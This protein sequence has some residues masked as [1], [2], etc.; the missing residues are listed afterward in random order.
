MS[1]LIAQQAGLSVAKRKLFE[2][3]M[4]GD[5]AADAAIP[6][7]PQPDSAPPLSFAQER[8]WFLDQLEPE[9]SAYNICFTLQ[10]S[11]SL[12]VVALRRAL[13]EI[14][15]RH[16]VLRAAFKNIKGQPLQVIGDVEELALLLIDLSELNEPDVEVERIA[17]VEALRPFE[18]SEGRLVRG[19][20][21]KLAEEEHVL[22]FTMHHII[23]DGWSR[24]ILVK[25]AAALY[26]SYHEGR[27][28]TLPEL[29]LQ[30]GDYASWQREYLQGERLE[31]GLSYWRKQLAGA[32]EVLELPLDYPRPAVRN[33]RGASEHRQLNRELSQRLRELS[34]REG[35]TLYMLLLAAF[36]TLLWRYS[37]QEQI[38]VGT[39]AA[40]RPRVE[41][42]GL[43]GFFV[44]TLVLRTDFTGGPSF[45]ELLGRV[46]EVCVGAYNHQE[47]PFKKLVEELEPER[48]LN[49]TPLFQVMFVYHNLPR[50]Q[51]KLPG[52]TLRTLAAESQTAKFDL[53]LVINDGREELQAMFE[54]NRDLFQSTTITRLLDQFETLLGSIVVAPE[55]KVRRLSLMSAAEV[56]EQLKQPSEEFETEGSLASWFEAV[57][58]RRREATAVVCGGE[59]LSYGELNERANQLAHYLRKRGV[60]PEVRVGLSLER[61]AEMVIGLLGI[62]KAGGAYVPLEQ[63]YPQA[64]LEFMIADAGTQIIVTHETFGEIEAEST[65]NPVPSASA[66][67]ALYVIYTSGTTGKPKGTVVTQGNVQ[68]LFQ[69]SA[70]WY[71]F[72]E[73]DVWTL[74][75]SYGFDFSVWEMWGALLYGGKLVV[76][77]YL[78]SRTPAAFYE[79]LQREQVTVL[80]QTP[81]AF[82][83]LQQAVVQGQGSKEELPLR[84]VI[85]GGEALAVSRLREWYEWY[86]EAGPRLVNMYGITETTVHVS[87]RELGVRDVRNAGSPIGWALPDL[88][89]YVLDEELKPVPVG[90]P[91]ELYVGGRGLARGYLNQGG[92]T[93]ARFVPHPYSGRGGE[94]LYRS[95]DRGRRLASGE[96]EYLGRMDQQVKIRGHR[97]ELAEIE[98]VLRSHPTVREAVAMLDEHQPG[99]QRLV[100]YVVCKDEAV[101]LRRYAAGRLPHY[102]VPAGIFK[103]PHLPLTN[104]GKVDRRKLATIERA[105][106]PELTTLTSVRTPVEEV[107][108]ATMLEVLG[109]ERVGVDDSFFDLGGHSLLATQV[110]GRLQDA[111]QVELP[112]RLLFE[113]PTVSGLA[114]HIETAIRKEKG[115]C[116]PPIE[117]VLRDAPLPLSFAQ[118]RLWFLGQLEP[119]N[120]VYNIPIALRIKGELNVA[121]L[122]RSLDEIIARHESLRTKL[123]TRNGE[124]FQII[125]PVLTGILRLVDLSELPPSEREPL[126]LQLANDDARRPFDLAQGPLLRATLLRL[127]EQ[128]HIASLTMHHVTSDGWSTAVLIGEMSTLYDAFSNGQPSPLPPLSIQ[129]ADYAHWQRQWLQG[130]VLQSQLSYWK[131]KLAGSRPLLELPTDYS[132]PAIQT[133]RGARQSIALQRSLSN[134]LKSLCRRHQV[135]LFMTLL[136][137][138]KTLL[139]RYSN[140]EDICVGSPIANRVTR[141][142]EALIGYIANTLVLR[143]DLSGN[144][145]FAE[146]LA[147]VREVSLGAYAFQDLSF[148]KLVDELQ[149]ARDLS[150]S[151]LFQVMFTLQNM[152]PRELKSSGLRLSPIIVENHTAKFD[153]ELVVIETANGMTAT[154]EYNLDLFTGETVT[155]M[156]DNFAVM[157][158]SIVANPEQR[159][160]ELP[161]LS[162]HEQQFLVELNQ[163]KMPLPE[164]QYAHRLFELQVER[165]PDAVAAVFH[166]VELTYSELN[167]RANRW[168][169][170]LVEN[171]VGP[172]VLVGALCDRGVNLLTAMLAIAKAGGTYLPLD[173][174][175]P[176]DRLRLEI[177]QSSCGLVLADREYVSLIAGVK[178]I[179]FDELLHNNVANLPNRSTAND[180]AYVIYTSG[181]TGIPKGAMIENRGMVNHLFAKITELQMTGADRVAQTASQS[182]DI[183]VWQFIAPLL[184]GARVHV[185]HDEITHD[186]VRL[187]HE[188]EAQGITI[189]ETVPSL[190]RA[191]LD[192]NGFYPKL[193]GL[194]WL[195]ITGEALPPELCRQ[196]LS[197]YPQIP[198]LNAYGPT[199]CSDDVTHHEI[200]VPPMGNVVRMPIGHAVQNTRLY[201]LDSHGQPVPTGV[202]GELY[203]GGAGVGRGYLHDPER[204]AEVF[205]PDPFADEPGARL[206]RSGDL[207]RYSADGN[208]EFIGRRDQQMKI[209]GFRIELG[210]IEVAVNALPEVRESL[211]LA[212]E[213]SPGERYLVLYL[214]FDRSL[215]A[216]STSELRNLLK[217][218][219]PDYMIPR[220]FIVLDEFP[221]TS[222]GKIDRQALPVPDG[223]RPDLD[224]EFVAPSSDVEKE[225]ARIWAQVLGVDQV[226]TH[227]NFFELGGDS[228]LMIQIISRAHQAGISLTLRQVFQHQTIAELAQLPSL[229]QTIE[230]EQSLITGDMPLT[231][232]QHWFIEQEMVEPHHYN[233][234][235][236]LELRQPMR[237]ALLK[238]VVDRLLEH[239]DG[240]RLRLA[241]NHSGWRQ[242]ISSGRDERVFSVVD[243]SSLP[244]PVHRSAI[245]KAAERQQA[246]LSLSDGPVLR[247]TLFDRGSEQT[248]RLLIVVHHLT[249]DGVSWRILLEDL[250]SAYEQLARAEEIVLPPKTTSFKLW[251]ERLTAHAQN[252]EVR[253]EVRYWV[254]DSRRRRQAIPL[255]YP[256]GDNTVGSARLLTVFLNAGET[257]SLLQNIPTAYSTRIDEVLLTALVLTFARW[258]GR[259]RLLVDLE[260]HGREE[261][262]PDVDLSRTIGWFTA[263]YPVLLDI[264]GASGPRAALQAVKAQLRE[265][266]NR[267]L[268]YGL[269]RYLT[270]NSEIKEQ[271]RELPQA[272]V[273][274][275]YL[276][277]FDQSFSESSYFK[278]APEPNGTR[279]NRGQNR[280]HLLEVNGSIV[281]RELHLTWIYNEKLHRESTIRH[282]AHGFREALQVLIAGV[283][284]TEIYHVPGLPDLDL[285]RGKLDN[286]LAELK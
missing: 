36:Q 251:A 215:P 245:E 271:L 239:H 72:D 40:N 264:G 234:A 226:G 152:P 85:F 155:R 165:T 7:R 107:V 256:G 224:Q 69:A 75:H 126:A 44:N 41:L 273:I 216:L 201:V 1:N 20:L 240:F 18:L 180:L 218:R 171:G 179:S 142:V 3:W 125:A 81:S 93:A 54:Y 10:L 203:I 270:T 145:S 212:R 101:D 127:D 194:R 6:R 63:S 225:L 176:V 147:R 279:R 112:L 135:T 84:L 104:N 233:Q 66:E 242:F 76:V 219:L 82:W 55:T 164:E 129:Y 189:W 148:E 73:R 198:L 115:L 222:N 103:I 217:Q 235:V 89:L 211:A 247:F 132:R 70:R 51:L 92:L 5:H 231:P 163:T 59:Q 166:E 178:V 144:P 53:S 49:H 96:I 117:R 37:R 121:A 274:F 57:A 65:A 12:D 197:L 206:Y 175:H 154:M 38:S 146:L 58:A 188:I 214:V 153:L 134:A 182:F 90:V 236:L 199:E 13:S 255:D 120:P 151:P 42:E 249:I 136:A 254:T 122:D 160:A 167:E 227:D 100:A 280:R 191:A 86:G 161:L 213:E 282:L 34:Q 52:L 28:S 119:G 268:S 47:V 243:L 207:A 114:R 71:E 95:G 169:H 143:T 118:Q 200:S 250:Q 192:V 269:L 8:L 4:R 257:Q 177:T 109:I 138:F 19:M 131:E 265:L 278:L 170:W 130:D 74:F 98:S 244:A 156:L 56:A 137:A 33:Y 181:S 267:G 139:Y 29:S 94:R 202:A 123:Q 210:E 133:F 61:V 209:R 285:S 105:E 186:A 229:G 50:T 204:T 196:W 261:I 272:D 62:V 174:F 162:T 2:Q 15:R 158:E 31:R 64:R 208:M 24:T 43:I 173:P 26:Q 205:V 14:L 193:S 99:D 185:F 252:E 237:A 283:N 108:A 35:V 220:T 141:E 116:I 187:L 17:K 39:V 232:A 83:Q 238:R 259:K 223:M 140:Q 97:V 128:A 221:L 110:M 281:G 27:S 157:L 253:R 23:S 102:M 45:R 248:A 113:M 230:A 77:P 48:D 11:G 262:F 183:S 159:I 106:E 263:I 67:N 286:I 111:F 241:K 46:R 30:Y 25:E 168:A 87:Y 266:P 16:E 124:P 190:L 80:N 88:E 9:S 79:L 246:S 150:Y 21:L 68:R 172:E 32:A 276:G 78:V 195:V 260:S 277:Q 275:N 228:I 258:T 149:P 22:L 184:A 60:G 284:E 91:G